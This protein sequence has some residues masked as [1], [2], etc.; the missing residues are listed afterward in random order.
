MNCS[1]LA[2]PTYKNSLEQAYQFNVNT[3]PYPISVVLDEDTLVPGVDYIL[4]PS[5]GT[6]AGEFEL[7]EINSKTLKEI[8]SGSISFKSQPKGQYLYAF[9]FTDIDDKELLKN[10]AL[11]ATE[12]MHY[13][14]AIWVTR[15]KPTAW[16]AR[17]KLSA[18]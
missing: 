7:V 18:D 3:F 13:F 1:A 14:P 9:N 5:S 15:K 8:Y 10:I 17:K 4:D 6:A 2:F 12:A 11:L 16:A